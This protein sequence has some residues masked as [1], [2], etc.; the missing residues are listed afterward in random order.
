VPGIPAQ[1]QSVVAVSNSVSCSSAGDCAAGG[2]Y[3]D[4]SGHDQAYVVSQVNG[5]WDEAIEVPGTAAL[6]VGGQAEVESVSCSSAGNCAAGG[7]YLNSENNDR[8]FVVSQVNGTWGQAIQV[9]A[10]PLTG[11]AAG[12]DS[13]SCAQTGYCMAAGYYTDGSGRR[14]A[15]V[16]S[17]VNGTWGQAIQVPGT[18]ALGATIIS[19][20]CASAGNCGVGGYTGVIGSSQAFVVSQVNGTWGQVIQVPGT[21]SGVDAIVDSVS[22]PSAGNCA[23]AGYYYDEDDNFYP[24]FVVNLVNGTWGQLIQEPALGAIY[25]VS[26]GSAGNCTAAG[27]LLVSE[28]NGTWGEPVPMRVPG[29]NGKEFGLYSVSCP[30][31]GNCTAAGYYTDLNGRQAFAVS[32]VN[33]TW[34]TPTEL[35]GTAALN[36]GGFDWVSSLSCSSA[37]NC[38]ASGFYYGYDYTGSVRAFV[39]SQV[40]GTWGQAIQ[41]P[42]TTAVGGAGHATVNAV[43]CASAGNCSAGG[44]FSD[45]EGNLRALVASQVKGTWGQA[46]QVPGTAELGARLYATVTSVSCASAGNCAAAGYYIDPAGRP[47]AFV[48]SQV[49]GAWGQAIQV[50]G[51]AALGTG[52]YATVS[53]VSC[54][55]AGNCTAGGYYRDR[56]GA[57]NRA[58]VTSQVRGRWGQAIQVPGTAAL[59]TGQG[60]SV[61]S[62]SCPSAGNCSAAGN[63]TGNSGHVQAF[64]V[65]QVKGAWGQAIQVPGTAA[66][67]DGKGAA[68][69]SVSCATAGNCSAAGN[70]TK[71]NDRLFLVSQVNGTWRT[72]IHVQG[73]A[74][75]GG[76]KFAQVNSV[77]CASAGNCA[78]GG[79]SSTNGHGTQ[80][81]VIDQVNGAWGKAIEVPGT[82]AI[83]VTGNAAVTSVSCP[84]AG[85]CSAGGYY[86]GSAGLQGG[87]SFVVS[88][89]KGTWGKAIQVRGT[90]A[91]NATGDTMISSV[92]CASAGNCVAGGYYG[93]PA[94]DEYAFLVSQVKGTWG[95]AI[96]VPGTAG[97]R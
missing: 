77:S 92:S 90:A 41:V 31:A 3:R 55:S 74:S 25:G 35:P 73:L 62:V 52:G 58:F 78:A 21:G 64:V 15:F 19:V 94:G 57:A 14:Q 28:V 7:Y 97:S 89:V 45:L 53:S 88:Q 1:P 2:Y 83:N 56:A 4:R 43:S 95:K 85:N 70:Y 11:R 91:F 6:N 18:A 69:I 22:C 54:A 39:A 48:A 40:N 33:G 27:D 80:A 71:F 24:G 76:A 81:F 49:R 16:V 47:Q 26:C 96:Q 59:G 79:T 84:S 66:G 9:P 13:V 61:I 65:S 37:G 46:I 75:P 34:G 50:P 38:A 12:V 93:D 8:T 82:A 30:S 10:V 60:A 51:T 42:G 36:E 87:R 23:A 20:S 63:Y 44:Y 68:A 86:Y 17:Q 5:S 32:Q 67:E 29:E 72:A